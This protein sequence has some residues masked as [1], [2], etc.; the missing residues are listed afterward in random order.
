MKFITQSFVVQMLVM[1]IWACDTSQSEE[2]ENH[3]EDTETNT[4]PNLD[5]AYV[6]PEVFDVVSLADGS[7]G[8]VG[9][10]GKV[11]TTF[12][13]GKSPVE[14]SS[15]NKQDAMALIYGNEYELIYH[16]KWGEPIR[17]E[18]A[19]SIQQLSDESLI[20]TGVTSGFPNSFIRKHS[21]DQTLVWETW[22][23]GVDD[24]N[25][26]NRTQLTAAPII[27]SDQ[28]LIVA[29][30]FSGF[31]SFD[32]GDTR[33]T[34]NGTTP[35]NAFIARYDT[36][37]GLLWAQQIQ[38]HW[39]ISVAVTMGEAVVVAGVCDQ[40]CSFNDQEVTLTVDIQDGYGAF[41]AEYG[42][43]GTF[44]SAKLIGEM[45]W[46]TGAMAIGAPDGAFY[47]GGVYNEFITLGQGTNQVTLTDPNKFR[48]PYLAKLSANGDALWATSLDIPCEMDELRLLPD[49]RIFLSG[50]QMDDSGSMKH[51]SYVWSIISNEDYENIATTIISATGTKYSSPKLHFS[52]NSLFLTGFYKDKITFA[53]HGTSL[54][55]ENNT[56][57]GAMFIA[58]F[59][60]EGSIEWAGNIAGYSDGNVIPP[61]ID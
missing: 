13:S 11:V 43:D 23:R 37:G 45:D 39:I 6:L 17:V 52:E 48:T 27:L 3:W 56:F 12:G 14:L 5:D 19:T 21:L 1:G 55:I 18:S 15:E 36:D 44:H 53:S 41:L 54:A 16:S 46:D 26:A 61:L 59:N 31:M 29:G 8:V 38:V 4:D 34:L 7:F 32:D 24:T 50:Y 58:K 40:S 57:L 42:T 9:Q 2:P 33:R 35:E 30:E 28:S 51:G 10:I 60:L 22:I 25:S 49:G 20:I 47:V